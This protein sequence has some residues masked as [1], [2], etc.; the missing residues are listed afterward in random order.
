ML[1]RN[2][3]LMTIAVVA[4][5][6]IGC[7]WRPKH[8]STVDPAALFQPDFQWGERVPQPP[9][10]LEVISASAVDGLPNIDTFTIEFRAFDAELPTSDSTTMTERVTARQSVTIVT[11]ELKDEDGLLEGSVVSDG[12]RQGN[13]PVLNLLFGRDD[14]PYDLIVDPPVRIGPHKVSVRLRTSTYKKPGIFTSAS[15]GINWS[16]TV[17]IDGEFSEPRYSAMGGWSGAHAAELA[18]NGVRVYRHAATVVP[19]SNKPKDADKK[20]SDSKKVDWSDLVFTAAKT[21][22]TS[23]GIRVNGLLR[24]PDYRP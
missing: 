5:L 24:K 11:D 9:E 15:D 1:L 2:L 18:I 6:A 22:A 12:G 17:T 4:I 16:V 20:K 8:A 23:D 7:G 10:P 13:K 14:P 19:A 21:S 3:K